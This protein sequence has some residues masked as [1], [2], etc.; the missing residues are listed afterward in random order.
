[1]P[2][3]LSAEDRAWL[4]KTIGT[5]E[6]LAQVSIESLN[7]KDQKLI[8]DALS[9]SVSFG[10]LSQ[11]ANLI[12]RCERDPWIKEETNWYLRIISIG[13]GLSVDLNDLLLDGR[14]TAIGDGVAAVK[15]AAHAR[16]ASDPKSTAMNAVKR[17]YLRWQSGQADYKNGADFA[18]AMCLRY[19][20]IGN[21]RSIQNK[22]PSWK[23]QKDP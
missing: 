23:K 16:W 20:E 5:E 12:D 3:V 1:M 2:R 11:L 4:D 8:S 7:L 21:E 17:E 19:P 18:R 10:Y 9:I 13:F 14:A 15:K 22:I 6:M